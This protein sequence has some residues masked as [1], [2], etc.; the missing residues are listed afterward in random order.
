MDGK[1]IC[2]LC[3]K[4]FSSKKRLIYHQNKKTKCDE[5]KNICEVCKKKFKRKRDLERHMKRKNKCK[6]PEETKEIKKE[7]KKVNIVN[8]N[9]YNITATMMIKYCKDNYPNAKN[10]EEVLNIENLSEEIKEECDG[11]NVMEDIEKILDKTCRIETEIRPIH[12]TD[13]S[14]STFSVKSKNRWEI[15]SKGKKIRENMGKC[16][17]ALYDKKIKAI[18]NNPNMT[19]IK[20]IEKIAKIYKNNT[21][22]TYKT[23][24][25]NNAGSYYV[26]NNNNIMKNI[27][28]IEEI[29]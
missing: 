8:Y 21:D 25:S 16:V 17:N 24:I 26:K 18:L 14:R 3:N 29:E 6:P 15:D 27:A 9:T 13:I 10:I 1:N 12:C 7:I 4:V 19:P 5:N 28:N 22:K 23:V 11:E 20:K 2:K